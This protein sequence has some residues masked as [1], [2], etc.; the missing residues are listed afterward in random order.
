MK[1]LISFLKDYDNIVFMD[2]FI[3]I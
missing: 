1:T 3:F 2:L